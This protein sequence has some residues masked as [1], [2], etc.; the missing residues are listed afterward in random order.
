MVE[1]L[2]IDFQTQI[3]PEIL[4]EQVT[5]EFELEELKEAQND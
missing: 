3:G 1:A 2:V 5:D 4:V